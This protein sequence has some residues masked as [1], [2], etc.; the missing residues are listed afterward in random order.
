MKPKKKPKKSSE[1]TLDDVLESIE[2]ELD[3]LKREGPILAGRPD[4]DRILVIPFRTPGQGD[5]TITAL[6][7]FVHVLQKIEFTGF[8]H[9]FDQSLY[10][11]SHDV[12]GIAFSDLDESPYDIFDVFWPALLAQASSL[13]TVKILPEASVFRSL[14][15]VRQRMLHSGT[16]LFQD[17]LP[18]I[19]F[20]N[21]WPFAVI[22]YEQFRRSGGNF[23]D[24]YQDPLQYRTDR[25]DLDSPPKLDSPAAP[26]ETLY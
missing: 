15:Y 9:C 22:C 19:A 8:C 2:K 6:R 23:S 5:Y 4:T 12:A 17:G 1:E 25:V 3:Q 18:C 14:G 26:G 11:V 10:Q 16:V 20:G 24:F 13:S 7:V 21:H